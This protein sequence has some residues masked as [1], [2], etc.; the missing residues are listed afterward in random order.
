MLSG[1]INNPSTGN[2]PVVSESVELDRPTLTASVA[3]V[4]A[5]STGTVNLNINK[6]T[7]GEN[8][9]EQ[10]AKLKQLRKDK[11]GSGS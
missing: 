1:F 4:F 9:S 10:L 7:V 8:I 3:D 2:I 5:A 11:A 6:E